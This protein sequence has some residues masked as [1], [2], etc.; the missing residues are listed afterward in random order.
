MKSVRVMLVEDD[1]PTR[2]RLSKAITQH[3]QLELVGSAGNCAQAKALFNA[4]P[5]PDVLLTDI[6]LPD[7]SGF[8]LIRA[9]R[10]QSEQIEIMVI[11]VFA[12]EKNVMTALEAGAT[13]YLLKD[14][15]QDNIGESVIQLVAGHSPLS[16]AIARHVLKRFSAPLKPAPKKT[17]DPSTEVPNITKRE[18]QVLECVAKGFSYKETAEILGNSVHTVTSHAK[19]IYR[20]LSVKSRSEAVYEAI[21]LGIINLGDSP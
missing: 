3:T 6:G 2:K 16:P 11:T 12:D 4:H 14:A 13:G 17:L 15:S 19:K 20:K 18:K 5:M 9:L 8:D 1:P 21:Q 10:S 7:G